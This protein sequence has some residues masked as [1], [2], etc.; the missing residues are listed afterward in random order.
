MNKNPQK[1]LVIRNDK[2]GDFMLSYPSFALLKQALPDCITFAL[3]PEYT[4]EMAETCQW[5]DKIIIDPGK[6]SGLRELR[7][8]IKTVRSCNINAAITLFSTT[9]IGAA[10][11]AA[12]IPYRLAPATKAAQI[13]Y[14]HKLAQRRSR[15]E[16]PEFEYN[17]DLVR[18]YLQSQKIDSFELPKP[19]YLRFNE[20]EVQQIKIAFCNTHCINIERPIV[21]I[22]P[23]SGG[24]A[25][26]LS[27]EQYQQLAV[28]LEKKVPINIVISAGPGEIEY[29]GKLAGQPGKGHSNCVV[30]QSTEGLK[31][32][33]QHIQF[34][35]VFISGSTGPLHIAGALN[36]ATAAF[37]PRRRSATSLRWQTLNSED[38]RL[39]F[40]P[41]EIAEENDMRTINI[42]EAAEE[43]SGK[44]LLK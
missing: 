43:I 42:E 35:D 37:Y 24:S 29:A 26:N 6:D 18:Y 38:K 23:G 25:N 41:P 33:A 28:I 9:R 10:L 2:L 12:G 21:F 39:S 17:L 44:F 8:L 34:A 36:T 3:V 4:R 31:R 16:K 32:F 5:I 1:I 27:L 13:L 20:N 15:S 40:S 30:Y 11:A 22:H 7:G 19:P 14:N